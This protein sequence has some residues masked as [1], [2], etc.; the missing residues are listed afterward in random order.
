MR[1][2]ITTIVILILLGSGAAFPFNEPDGF[3]GLKWGS[4]LAEIKAKQKK[5]RRQPFGNDS[6]EVTY[7]ADGKIGEF[8]AT[9][10]YHL[11]DGR[12]RAVTVRFYT[13]LFDDVFKAFVERYGPPT[14]AHDNAVWQGKNSF[15]FLWKQ[16]PHILASIQSRFYQ[17]FTL[18]R[19]KEKAK[20]AAKDL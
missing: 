19:Q 17:D 10:E 7:V 8:S 13:V 9:I 6:R 11:V 3:A 18:S 20:S 2:K 4:S 16:F 15:I 5:V 1:V 14:T 12:L